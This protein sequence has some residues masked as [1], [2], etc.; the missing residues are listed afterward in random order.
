MPV[1]VLYFHILVEHCMDNDPEGTMYLT[2]LPLLWASAAVCL[3]VADLQVTV[4]LLMDVVTL[5]SVQGPM[6][7]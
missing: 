3:T 5:R 6:E 4:F 2:S 7:F 1:D